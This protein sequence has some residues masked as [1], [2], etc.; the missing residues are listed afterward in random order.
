MRKKRRISHKGARAKG[1]SFERLIANSL[2][3]IFPNARRQLE[4]HEADCNGVDI[5]NTEHFKFQCKK[6][7]RYASITAIEEVQCDEEIGDIPVLVTAG[8]GQRPMAVL[9]FDDFLILLQTAKR[10]GTRGK[11]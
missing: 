10:K 7:R 8:D 6:L 4:Y 9:P 1:H 5:A 3:E 2:K 11:K